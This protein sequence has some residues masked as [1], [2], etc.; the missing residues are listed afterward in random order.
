MAP[1]PFGKSLGR[2]DPIRELRRVHD[3][4]DRLFGNFFQSPDRGAAEAAAWLP[5]LDLY[6]H[7]DEVVVILDLPGVR[8][9]DV[10]L[11]IT[12][13]VLA[14]RGER[15]RAGGPDKADQYYAAELQYGVF[16]RQIPLPTKVKNDAA[17]AEFSDGVLTIHL[18]KSDEARTREIKVDVR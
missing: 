10:Q 8:R 2:W 9:E 14:V 17:R 6:E 5:A 7:K 3:D 1:T 15:R 18:P 13:D 11:T 12:G 16:L 4:M